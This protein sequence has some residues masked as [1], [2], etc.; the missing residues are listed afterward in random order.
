MDMETIGR[1]LSDSALRSAAFAAVGAFIHFGAIQGI[2]PLPS[3]QP[4]VRQ[5][6]ALAMVLFG[7]LALAGFI[8][9]WLLKA[10]KI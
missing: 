7:S 1:R 2:E 5:F 6:A 8:S 3:L 9:G 10:N 4:W